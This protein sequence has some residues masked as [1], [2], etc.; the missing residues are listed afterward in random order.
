[1]KP[2]ILVVDDEP[3]IR[4]MVR[5]IL[6]DEGYDVREAHN[7]ETAREE[8]TRKPP[9]LIIL[10]IWMRQSDMDGLELQKWIRRYYPHVPT[11]MISGHGNIETAVQAMKDGAFDFVEKP[12]KSGQLILLCQRALANAARDAEHDELKRLNSITLDQIGSSAAITSIR[13]TITKVAPT[14]S[15]IFI[16]GPSGSGKELLARNIHAQ[17]SRQKG[18]FVMVNCALLSSERSLIEL[19]G[20]ESSQDGNRVVGLFEQAHG[21]TLYFDEVCDLPLETQAKLVRTLQDQ[22]FRRV[23]GSSE[24]VVDVRVISASSHDVKTQVA[25]GNFREDLY[26][27]LS[28][29]PISVPPLSRRREDIPELARYFLNKRLASEGG[30]KLDFTPAS[31]ATLESYAWPGNITQLR[32]TVDWLVIMVDRNTHQITPDDLPSEITG[33][34]GMVSGDSLSGSVAM[35]LKEAREQFETQYLI[36]QLSR[37]NGNISKT[38]AFI[39]MER[40]ALH[41]K[42]KNLGIQIESSNALGENE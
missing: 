33:K 35:P 4:S 28:V 18:R 41:R 7:A 38:A 25:E 26:Y 21:G 31:I 37:F 23:G 42:L 32:N 34:S 9:A 29:V 36:S 6:E 8:L 22:R 39:G 11:I 3:D 12:F 13:Q 14:N 15:R 5:L 20:S 27:R 30:R 40:S 1:M 17:S 24:V 10:D 16:T 19:F 2:E